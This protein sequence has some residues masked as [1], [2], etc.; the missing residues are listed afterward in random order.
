[1][2]E[3]HRRAVC[4]AITLCSYS[5]KLSLG[6]HPPSEDNQRDG[7][8][9]NAG[10]ADQ[11][12]KRSSVAPRDACTHISGREVAGHLQKGLPARRAAT[13]ARVAQI[14]AT[15]SALTFPATNALERD[16]S[17]HVSFAAW[18]RCAS[19]SRAKAAGLP[20]ASMATISPLSLPERR[21]VTPPMIM[22][23]VS[24]SLEAPAKDGCERAAITAR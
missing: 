6:P 2:L 14:A 5:H 19:S 20:T 23:R 7:D 22:P 12:P 1:M 16:R 18:L 3:Q 21:M 10:N 4:V 15:H 17:D 8:D 11:D 9:D 13:H 24:G